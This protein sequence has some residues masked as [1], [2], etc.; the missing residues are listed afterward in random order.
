MRL[1]E[2]LILWVAR[3]QLKEQ[4][5]ISFQKGWEAGVD[6]QRTDPESTIHYETLD[7]DGIPWDEWLVE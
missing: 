5:W 4:D 3:K 7:E 6:Q 1:I 2:K